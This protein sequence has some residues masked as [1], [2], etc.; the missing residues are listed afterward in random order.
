MTNVMTD[1]QAGLRGQLIKDAPLAPYVWFRVGGPADWLF[2]PK[3]VADLQTLLTQLPPD[4]PVTVLG[5]GSN[6][7][8][9]DGGIPGVVV[10]LGSGFNQIDVLDN[11]HIQ[12]G[13]AVPDAMLARAAAKA[14][15]GGLEFFRGIPGTVGGACVMN[16][17]CYGAETVDVF[18][19][20]QALTR[21]GELITLTKDDMEFSYRK[22]ARVHKEN[23]IFASA[24]FNGHADKPDEITARMD[25]ITKRR[26]STQPVRE[27]TGGS[28]FK[29]PDGHKSWQLVDG[30]GWRGKGVGG[31]KFSDLHANFLINTGDATAADIEATG[32]A[33][34]A[35]VKQQTGVDLQWEI[36]R[37]G[38]PT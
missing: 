14:G 35:A 27:K 38:N 9:R 21:S 34:R 6:V 28:T 4:V 26:E 23:L 24:I 10:R 37:I 5:V 17:G 36:K 18:V 1:W 19:S 20:A 3:D 29:N 15:I 2:L 25:D 16:A 8:V 30:A 11:H 22:S 12:A 31:A 13:A 7:L 33:A 32:E